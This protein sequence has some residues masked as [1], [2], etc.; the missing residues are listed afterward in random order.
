M[1]RVLRLKFVRVTCEPPHFKDKFN[2]VTRA[3]SYS[4]HGREDQLDFGGMSEEGVCLHTHT[5][6]NEC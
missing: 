5:R 2:I 1:C 6:A 4:G 3:G